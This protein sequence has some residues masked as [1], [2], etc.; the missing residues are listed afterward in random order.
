MKDLWVVTLYHDDE[1]DIYQYGLIGI[2]DSKE[3]ALAACTT[4][5][6]SLGP[7]ELNYVFDDNRGIHPGEY[8]PHLETQEE[9]TIRQQKHLD[10]YQKNLK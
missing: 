2:F 9:G 6:H 5:H 8:Y 7:V 4:D 1:S 10:E 3:K